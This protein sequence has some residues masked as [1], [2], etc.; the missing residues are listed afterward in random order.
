MMNKNMLKQAQALQARLVKAQQ[1]I[2][3][4]TAE[5][6]SGG[7]AVKAVVTGDQQIKSVKINPEVV[8]PQEVEMLEDLVL[9]AVKDALDKSRQLAQAHMGKITGGLGLPGL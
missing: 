6:T 5:G 8:N 2:A 3:E 9:S 4:M 7:G 1:E